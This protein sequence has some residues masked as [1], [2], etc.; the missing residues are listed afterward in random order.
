MQLFGG[1][2]SCTYVGCMEA[3]VDHV[4]RR[5]KVEASR[6][7]LGHVQVDKVRRKAERALIN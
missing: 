3:L 1:G 4:S 2:G 5:A 6:A 7:G